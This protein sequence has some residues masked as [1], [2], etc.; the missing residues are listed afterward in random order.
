MGFS[1]VM[2]DTTVQLHSHAAPPWGNRCSSSRFCWILPAL[3]GV[4]QCTWYTWLKPQIFC[5]F[6]GDGS[7]TL[8]KSSVRDLAVSTV[9]HGCHMENS[10]GMG[11]WAQSPNHTFPRWQD[12]W[13]QAFSLSAEIKPL[14]VTQPH[15][16]Q[17]TATGLL[18]FNTY[19]SKYIWGL[20]F[21][22]TSIRTLGIF[23]SIYLLGK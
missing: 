20:L 14:P 7:I 23:F 8:T 17:T 9:S 16:N 22:D 12:V 1:P 10:F 3:Y 21:S 4:S 13:C 19:L 5:V 15:T 11:T 6:E 2:M 18:S